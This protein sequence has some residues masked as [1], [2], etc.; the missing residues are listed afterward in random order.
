MAM[1]EGSLRAWI[2]PRV[3]SDE[4]QSAG[5]L[6][7][8]DRAVVAP[9]DGVG[10]AIGLRGVEEE[11]MVGIAD[12]RRALVASAEPSPP[13]EDDAVRGVGL[14]G[15]RLLAL[16]LTA[17]VDDRDPQG[18]EEDAPTRCRHGH[19]MLLAHVTRRK[20]HLSR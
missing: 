4:L 9:R 12:E 16:G 10:V 6:D 3:A 20:Y 2:L 19:S 15:S 1:P 8:Q 5:R 14:L 13:D 11:N 17:K 7:G 18:R